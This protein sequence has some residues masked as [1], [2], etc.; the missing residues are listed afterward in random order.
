MQQ[1]MEDPDFE[2]SHLSID[3]MVELRAEL[4]R[5]R[6]RLARSRRTTRDA[7]RP[8]ALDQTAVGRV[9]RIDA[10]QNQ[11]M[12]RGL[13]ERDQARAAQI[14]EALRRMD[15]GT[16]GRCAGCGQPIPYER[17]LVFPEAQACA[18]CG[19]SV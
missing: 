1:M 3:Q 4:E 5:A 7:A 13:Q 10:I 11:S 8:V 2:H 6:T 15:A 16:Y 9:S 14:D 19:G 18:G 17:L 12:T